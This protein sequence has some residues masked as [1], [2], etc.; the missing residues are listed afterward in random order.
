MVV[1]DRLFLQT[2]GCLRFGR[3][4]HYII[5]RRILLGSIFFILSENWRELALHYFRAEC[6]GGSRLGGEGQI[7]MTFRRLSQ[8]WQ[9]LALHYFLVDCFGGIQVGSAGQ[10]IFRESRL[11]E[12]WRELV[13][14]YFPADCFGIVFF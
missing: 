10:T 1:T 11:S 2:A 7:V 13:P 4:W 12:I 3:N 9:E 6:S 14:H 5:I 8:I